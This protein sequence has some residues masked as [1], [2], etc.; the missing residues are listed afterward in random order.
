MTIRYFLITFCFLIFCNCICLA[1]SAQLQHFTGK[2]GLAQ[3]QVYCLLEDQRGYIWLGTQGGG[4]NRF[5]GKEFQNWRT[6]NGLSNNF[7]DA[8]F[9]DDQ[10]IIWIGTKNGLSSYNGFEFKNYYPDKTRDISITTILQKGENELW[11]GTT[12]GL[13]TFKDD[14]WIRFTGLRSS[15]KINHL[16]KNDLGFWVSTSRGL[17]RIQGEQV[18]NYRYNK[19]LST[20]KIQCV[21]EASDG[22]IWVGTN[23]DGVYWIDK[24][25]KI[26]QAPDNE[27]KG[28]HIQTIYQDKSNRI[29]IGS[30]R[31][32]I[33]IW[34]PTDSSYQYLNRETGL[35]RNDVRSLLEDRWGHLWIGTPGGLSRYAGQQFE[36]RMINPGSTDNSVYAICE[37]SLSNIWLSA[38]SKGIAKLENDELTYYGRDSGFV[39]LRC[40]SLFTDREQRLWIGAESK[41]L[42]F[43]DGKGFRFLTEAENF[44]SK[45]VKDII[46]DSSGRIWVATADDGIYRIAVQDSLVLKTVMVIDSI[47]GKATGFKMR[48]DTILESRF[49]ANRFDQFPLRGAYVYDLLLDNQE[50]LW[51]ASR[52]QGLGCIVNDSLIFQLKKSKGFADNHVRSIVTDE[53]GFLWAGTANAGIF[54]IDIENLL[55]EV[56]QISEVD[57]L[58]SNN[59]YS[60]L[61]DSK[62][63]LWAGAGKGADLI[64]LNEA[65]EVQ[66][67]QHFDQSDG[68]AGIE[69]STNAALKDSR[70]RIWFGTVNG[71]MQYL[72]ETEQENRSP[73]VVHLSGIRIGYQ[74]LK[75][76]EY[77]SYATDWGAAKDGLILPYDQNQLSFEFKAIHQSKP[78]QIRYEYLLK[79]WDKN[80]VGPYQQNAP[81]HYSN[82]SPGDYKFYV[83]A[84]NGDDSENSAMT[85]WLFTIEPPFWQTNLF[86]LLCFLGAVLLIFLLVQIWTRRI[87][88]Q[89]AAQTER[90]EMEK[91]MLELEQKALQLQM[92]PHFIFNVLNSIQSLISQKD[93]RT[94]RYFLAKFSKLMRSILENSREE[95]IPLE[96]EI[97]TLEHYLSVEKFSRDDQFDYEI[98]VD[99]KLDTDEIMMAPMLLQP[100]LE[101]AIIHGVGQVK[102]GGKIK[103]SFLQKYGTLE[104][105]IEDNGPGIA[106]AKERK[107]Q[108]EHTHKSAAL[109]VTRERLDIL[110]P[111]AKG[112]SLE[113]IDRVAEGKGEGTEVIVR[114]LLSLVK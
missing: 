102:E 67:I 106:A 15:A 18:T 44:K 24:E 47:E 107:S 76:S 111:L 5:D 112:K 94:A 60:L 8:L 110:N 52:D 45:F 83:R 28:Q 89:A 69:M 41:G 25:S 39:N 91:S 55:T 70:G 105:I 114:L 71:L 32:G 30:Q 86:Y 53:D 84:S 88:R 9:E 11:V 36:Q 17:H 97:K 19:N 90:L 46:Q 6:K 61:F 16:F 77:K 104:C 82:L 14:I 12:Q 109:D 73:P 59:V 101:N 3:S 49:V 51:F 38:S 113:I 68:F 23:D 13:Y 75:D 22:T 81:A 54:R 85:S 62:N 10:G 58:N 56:E 50:R 37:D 40:K 29:W 78:D 33:T 43:Y 99:P 80:W 87:R 21:A 98:Y 2:D 103:L 74:L 79:G 63:Q 95:K 1:Q 65:R 34:N 57:G 31:E 92:N 93:E 64:T 7:V 72:P 100:F 20:K 48:T 27:I 4:L 42:A 96:Q 26:T 66:S 35:L 108:Q